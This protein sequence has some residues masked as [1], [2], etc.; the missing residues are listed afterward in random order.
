MIRIAVFLICIS[1]CQTTSCQNGV[2]T[3]CTEGIALSH[4]ND[5]Y[6]RFMGKPGPDKSG[7]NGF[8]KGELVTKNKIW[9]FFDPPSDGVINIGIEGLES[10]VGTYVFQATSED[11]CS[12]YNRKEAKLLL[13]EPDRKALKNLDLFIRGGMRHAIVLI[14]EERNKDSLRVRVDFFPQDE[15][16]NEILDS[17][18][19]DLTSNNKDKR[20][21][22]HIRNE[23]TNKPVKARVSFYGANEIDG[24]YTASDLIMNLKKSIKVC[25]LK[26]DAQGYL[27]YDNEN[28]S[29]PLKGDY[30]DTIYLKPLVRGTVAKIDEIY[31]AAG[32]PTILEESV[33]K[34]NRLRDFLLVNPSVHIEIQGHVNGNGKRAFRSKTLSKRRAK[35]ILSY[36]E[37]A[38]VSSKRL[39][40]KGFG[41]TK[42]VYENPETEM[43]KEANRRVE[44]L[45]K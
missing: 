12:D 30:R 42:P 32:L 10:S 14:G 27:S 43:Q 9:L 22:L 15:F 8:G 28:Y 33:P 17:L 21:F 25:D 19:F 29:I 35:S 20:Y 7:L 23:Q 4:N 44:I 31:F 38:G 3:K 36:L 6:V 5:Y 26:I 45:I 11:V 2:Y 37:K 39:S 16:G 1:F 34:L 40:A 18:L 24:S 41:F 13:H